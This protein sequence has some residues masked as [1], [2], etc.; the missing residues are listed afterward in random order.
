MNNFKT[1][2]IGL[3]KPKTTLLFFDYI[4]FSRIKYML[5]SAEEVEYFFKIPRKFIKGFNEANIPDIANDFLYER[6]LKMAK[7]KY[8]FSPERIEKIGYKNYKEMIKI[9]NPTYHPDDWIH[10]DENLLDD[11]GLITSII[12]NIYQ[13]GNITPIFTNQEHYYRMND[14]VKD[15]LHNINCN[16]QINTDLKN[17]EISKTAIG[18]CIKGIPQILEDCLEW[19]QVEDFKLD[20][21]SVD[22]LR[23]FRCWMYDLNGKSENEIADKI[24]LELSEYKE[25]LKKHGIKYLPGALSTIILGGVTVNSLFAENIMWTAIGAIG[26]IADVVAYFTEVKTEYRAMK[27]SP[28]AFLHDVLEVIPH[29]EN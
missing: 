20:N 17:T 5:E 6:L 15:F 28:I 2:A 9:Y 27:K 19:K 1:F 7:D 4:L 10:Q 12:A 26:T 16:N 18:F 24:E 13:K 11:Y 29:G 3:T 21:Q 25:A 22:K 14:R 8:G 23:R